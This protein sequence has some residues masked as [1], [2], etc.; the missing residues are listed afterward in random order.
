M[1]TVRECTQDQFMSL[2]DDWALLLDRSDADP[3]FMSWAW[4][5]SWWEVWG[6]ELDLT[7]LLLAVY[8]E[9][10]QLV[11]LAPLYVNE[12]TTPVGWRV[13]RLHVVGNAWKLKPTVRTEYV[14]FIADIRHKSAA[15]AALA[16]YLKQEAWDELILAD[17]SLQTMAEWESQLDL[18]VNAARL[19]RSTAEGVVI[20]TSGEY[21]AWLAGLGKNTR[22]KAFNRRAL[23]E[24]ELRGTWCPWSD[25]ESFLSLLNE[26]HQERWGKACFDKHAVR[27]HQRL[28]ARLSDNQQARLSVL[29]SGDKVLSVLYDIRA[30]NR[31][32]NLQ[33]GFSEQFHSKISVGTLHLGY[34]I[35]QA[36]SDPAVV[37]YDLL[38][39]AGKNTFYKRHFKG[40]IVPFTTVE[41]VRSPVLKLAY[42]A[43]GFLPQGLVSSVN[44]FFRL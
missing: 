32:Y 27:F 35:E 18:H 12:F 13:R 22:L 2:Q 33:A 42:G 16:G 25:P 44:R 34:S 6:S 17:A 19:V 24:G 14:G 11:A 38:A 29:K 20:N 28:L 40:Q 21:S 23:F 7:L 30:G 9:N 39:G 4:Q 36:F 37:E 5:I 3:L 26:F 15:L 41:Y 8:D 31:I 1:Y 10:E 43:R